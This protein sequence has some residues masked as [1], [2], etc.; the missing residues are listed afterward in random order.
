M[1]QACLRSSSLVRRWISTFFTSGGL[2]FVSVGGSS[3]R[4]QLTWIEHTAASMAHARDGG[5]AVAQR[6]WNGAVIGGELVNPEWSACRRASVTSS[7][8]WHKF[9]VWADETRIGE[10]RDHFRVPLLDGGTGG[11]AGAAPWWLWRCL[12][13]LTASSAD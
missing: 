11:A 12:I 9:V 13:S 10:R 6:H 4:D 5:T 8:P 1:A 3:A 2:P 7:A